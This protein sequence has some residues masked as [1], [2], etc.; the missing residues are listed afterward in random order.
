MIDV[1][2]IQKKNFRNKFEIVIGR[3][4]HIHYID[5][6]HSL[7]SER[8]FKSKKSDRT[9]N[10]RRHVGREKR[11]KKKKK[12]I[13]YTPIYH[14]TIEIDQPKS[15]A[16]RTRA[17]SQSRNQHPTRAMFALVQ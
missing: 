14:R 11:K 9:R 3:H 10:D 2:T 8:I 17:A 16:R 6:R 12:R 1:F 5:E 15:K 7:E 13:C 4:L